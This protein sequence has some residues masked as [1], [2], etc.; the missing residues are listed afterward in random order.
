MLSEL[1]ESVAKDATV[2]ANRLHGLI[3]VMFKPAIAKGLITI[4]PMQWIDKPGGPDSP[5]KWVLSDEEIRTFWPQFEKLRSNPL[6]I[7]K[8]GLLTA[9]RP[10]E[11]MSMRWEDVDMIKGVWII[12][13][14]KVGNDHLVPL[15][16]QVAEI[17]EDRI[18]YQAR[19]A[20]RR[21]K[22][23]KKPL[24]TYQWV[25]Q[26][27]YNQSRGAEAGH[28]KSTKQARKKLI[29]E[30]GLEKWSAHDLRRSAR[31]IMSRLKIEPHIRELVLNHSVGKIQATYDVYDYLPEKRQALQKLA[32]EID[33][34]RGANVATGKVVKLHNTGS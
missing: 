15:S 3:R 17:L 7:L 21:A 19:E 9:Q 30:T 1:L 6:D 16:R 23:Y 2:S 14:T 10:G 11:I 12:R 20:D 5:K 31:T 13:D 4:H 24:E 34:I 22:R 26:S 32:N 25:F 33:R 29:A 28:A 8:L 18:E 27:D